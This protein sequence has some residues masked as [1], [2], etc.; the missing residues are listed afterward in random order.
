MFARVEVLLT[1]L[2]IEKQSSTALPNF[3]AD[4]R[5]TPPLRLACAV[6]DV[7]TKNVLL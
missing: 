6:H 1:T 7:T 3:R 2:L 4:A 5:C